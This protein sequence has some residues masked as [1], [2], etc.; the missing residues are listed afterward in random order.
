VLTGE[1]FETMPPEEPKHLES[2]SNSLN[3]NNDNDERQPQDHD[4]NEETDEEY[5]LRIYEEATDIYSA[6][7]GADQSNSNDSSVSL[8]R[9][10]QTMKREISRQR[11][12]LVEALPETPTGWIAFISTVSAALLG[13]EMRLQKTLTSP[14]LVFGQLHTGQMQ[15]IYK[16]M[17]ARADSILSRDIQPSLFV[18]TR[19]MVASTAAYLLHGP[20]KTDRHIRF[21][22]ILTM[23]QDGGRLALD[24]E[25]P[26]DQESKLTDEERK[27][28]VTKGPIKLPVVLILHG[29]NNNASFGYVKSLMRT[30][31]NRGWL[32]VGMNFRGCGGVPLAT[33]RAYNGAYTGDIRCVVWNLSARMAEGAPIFLVGNSLGASNLTKYMGEEGLAGTLPSCVA[34][35][36][37]LGNPLFLDSSNI[38]KVIAPVM[39]LGVKKT[40]IENWPALHRMVVQSPQF[41]SSITKALTAWSIADVD[42]ALCPILARNDP[43]APFGF[44]VGFKNGKSYWVDGSCYR[45]IR[46]ISV[47]TLQIVAG[48]DFLVHNS[49]KNRISYCLANPNVMVVE[50]RCGGHLGWQEAPP[51]GNFGSSSSWSDVATTDFIEAILE[52]RR[53]KS[54]EDNNLDSIQILPKEAALRARL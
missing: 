32:A 6:E 1:G 45:L 51:D 44:R 12:S 36:I 29:I 27:H 3:K 23:S 18:G 37:C 19:G 25:L 35:G 15:D 24:W 26:P 52:T 54:K 14:P 16:Q 34:G 2:E 17:T 7:S 30:C 8:R 49:F 46:F 47:P 43:V 38:G 48:D 9:I 13:Y 22:E 21:R 50:T 40:I 31:T 42:E 11:S 10:S 39:A 53:K 4:E 20:S 28:Q 33:P 5:R 41:R